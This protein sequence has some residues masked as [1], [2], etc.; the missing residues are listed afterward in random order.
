MQAG[1]GHGRA[2]QIIRGHA[3]DGLTADDVA[4]KLAISRSTLDRLL[5]HALG[6]SAAAVITNVRI[7]QIKADLVGTDLPL[8]AIAK[9]AGFASVQHLSNLFRDRVGSTLGRYRQDMRR[10]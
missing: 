2:L 10:G 5:R 9:R 7:T 1:C 8:K 3:C 4:A 6:Q